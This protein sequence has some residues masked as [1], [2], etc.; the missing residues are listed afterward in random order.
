MPGYGQRCPSIVAHRTTCVQA[1][2]ANAIHMIANAMVTLV[3]I[4]RDAQ[5]TRSMPYLPLLIERYAA[6]DFV[7]PPYMRGVEALH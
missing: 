6:R 7:T 4:T 3:R 2:G 1:I 5:I